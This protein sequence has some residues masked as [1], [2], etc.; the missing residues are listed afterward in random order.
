[1]KNLVFLF[2]LLSFLTCYLQWPIDHSSFVFQ[3]EYEAFIKARENFMS[4]LHPLILIP[5]LGQ[6]LVIIILFQRN[7]SKIAILISLSCLSILVLL[8]FI[9]GCIGLNYKIVLSTI[10]CIAISL[11]ILTNIKKYSTNINS[12]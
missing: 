3:I 10:P 8:I 9:V 7:P 2:L 11:Y 6:I 1:M 5:L 12:D 4:L